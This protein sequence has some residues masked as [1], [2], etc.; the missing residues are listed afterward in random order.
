M[1]RHSLKFV[2][3]KDYKAVTSD[4]KRIYQSMTEQ[5]ASLEL[6]NFRDKLDDK[7]PQISKSWGSNWENLIITFDYPADIRKVIY[8][9]NAIESLNSVI[10]KSVK[11][12][13]VFPSDDAALKVI[14]LATESASK[15]W[16]MTIRNW[17]AALNRFMIKFEEQLAPHI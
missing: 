8:T 16:T 3:W 12:R 5:E 4:L 1:V 2:P 13:K 14:Y 17:K 15:K 10:R 6:D 7:Y 11:T 9:T